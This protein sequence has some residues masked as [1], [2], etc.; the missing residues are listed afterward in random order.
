MG[1]PRGAACCPCADVGL[2]HRGAATTGRGARADLGISAAPF[3]RHPYAVSSRAELGRTAARSRAAGARSAGRGASA[4]TRAHGTA[5]AAARRS[6]GRG[7]FV[8]RTVGASCARLGCARRLTQLAD[9]NGAFVEPTGSS[10]E[11]ACA[12]R[13]NPRGTFFPRL[14]C[15]AAGVRGAATYRR[16]VV[17]RARTRRLGRPED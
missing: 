12:A 6:A 17:E 5:F 8:E 10:L 1:R 7:A 2:A 11:R 4:R 15:A 9:S 3:R 16:A 13:V 14:G